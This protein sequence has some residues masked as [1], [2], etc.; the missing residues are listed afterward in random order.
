MPRIAAVGD[1]HFVSLMH[2]EPRTFLALGGKLHDV[3]RLFR[4]F[5]RRIAI[6]GRARSPHLIEDSLIESDI[7]ARIRLRV[8]GLED[9]PNLA[10]A[11]SSRFVDQQ[12]KAAWIALGFQRTV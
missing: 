7:D 12:A 5:P 6:K 4:N 1:L 8:L 11:K 3:H 10:L 2:G 9:D